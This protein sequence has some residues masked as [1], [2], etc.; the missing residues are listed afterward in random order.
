MTSRTNYRRLIAAFLLL[1]GLFSVQ[2]PAQAEDIDLFTI[3]PEVSTQ[4]PNVLIIL[5][6]SANWDQTDPVEG[7]KRSRW[8]LSAMSSTI[9]ALTDQF[10][11]GLMMFAETGNPNDNI[12]G[13]VMR[14]GMRWMNSTNRSALVNFFNSVDSGFDKS[15][16]TSMGL[17]F[18]EA[19]LY[20]SGRAAYSGIGKAKR[21]YLGNDWST[22]G[23][24]QQTAPIAMQTA[25]NA[26]WNL[27]KPADTPLPRNA[28]TDLADTVYNTPVTDACQKNFII[29]IANGPFNDPV[30][31][32]TTATTK[33]AAEGGNT[34]PPTCNVGSQVCDF[35]AGNV[36]D[37]WARFLAN[38]SA[39]NLTKPLVIT[40]TVEVNPI[41]TGQGP[42]T[43]G[44]LESIATQGKGKYFPVS[45]TG[46]GAQ[47]ADALNKIFAEIAAVNS[48]FASSTLPVSVNVRGAFLNQVYMG[49]FR[50]D[51]NSSPRWPGNVKHYALSADS[52]GNVFLVDKAGVAIENP[53]TGFVSP[54]AVSFWTTASTFWD[55]VYYPDAAAPA[56]NTTNSDSPD[57]EFVEKGGAAQRL[58]TVYATTI[59]D[60]TSPRKLYT[61]IGC[62]ADTDLTSSADHTFT[63][64]NTNI[65]ATLMGITGTLSVNSLS[66]VG[67][68]VTAS[69]TA[70]GFLNGQVVQI[71]GATQAEYN[72]SHNITVVDANTFTYGITETPA[73]PAT[74]NSGTTLTAAK[75]G[76][77]QLVNSLTSSGSTATATVLLGHG[78][79]DGQS[80]TMSGASQAEYDGTYNITFISPTQ[81]SYTITTGPANPT[82]QGNIIVTQGDGGTASSAVSSMTRSGT[83]VTV[84][85]SSSVF[86]GGDT[87]A[88]VQI[89]GASPVVYNVSGRSC[90]RGVGNK[91]LTFELDATELT[92]QSPDPSLVIQADASVTRTIASMTRPVG[93]GT[94]TVVTTA[95]H[96]YSS[97]DAV[98]ISNAT[99][100][101]YNGNK[102]ITVVD[103][104]T[105]T[106]TLT[107]QPTTPAGGAITATGSGGLNKDDVINWARGENVKLDDN[108]AADA[109]NVRGYLHGDVLHSRPAVI[110][111]N[112]STEPAERDLVV[113]Y[114][115]NDGIIH[116]VK[117]GADD[118]DGF[119]KWGFVP[120]EFYPGFS[121]LYSESPIISSNNRRTYFADGP[122]SIDAVY[123]IDNSDPTNPK[124]RL[125][126]SLGSVRAQIYVGMRRG[127]RF[128][129][130]LDVTNPDVPVYKWKLDSATT[131]FT[132]LGQSW[133][134]AKVV[135]LRLA[136]CPQLGGAGICKV[137]VFGAGYDSPANDPE[138]QGTATMGRGI[139]VVDAV[140]GERIWH[141]GPSVASA[142]SGTYRRTAEMTYAIPADLSVINTDLDVQNLADRIY[143]ADTG[144]NIW[145][146]NVSDSNPANWTVYKLASLRTAGAE[147][148]R[149]FLFAPDVVQF[150]TTTDSVLIGS[151]DREHPHE[152]AILNR[153]YMIKDPHSINNFPELSGSPGVQDPASVVTESNLC[154]LTNNNLQGTDQGL[155]DADKACLATS[156]GWMI[157]LLGNEPPPC[158]AD[159]ICS[160]RPGEKTVTG[161]TTLGGTVIF[162][163]N[164]P[165]QSTLASGQ[166]TGSLGTALIYA[167]SFRDATATIDFDG[168][169]VVDQGDRFVERVGGGFPPTAIPFTT[170]IGDKFYEG[171][172][173]GTKVV[174][175]PT[176]PIGQ[177][178]RVFWNLSVDN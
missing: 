174:Q 5:D 37:E 152:T 59:N 145:R 48:V 75:G 155:I 116:A 74:A 108:T 20:Y 166:C 26:I 160:Q 67:E 150:D 3:N 53:N 96:T 124:E 117:G 79:A 148:A 153:Y 85:T 65:T 68:T 91:R 161:A 89:T 146:V 71:Q 76:A 134:E 143:A 99:D 100:A 114:G 84:D 49:V 154:D 101:L 42:N 31:S 55:P 176:S 149:K 141:T 92:P 16:N 130:S 102:T 12:D 158:G 113:Y 58:R 25:S 38:P 47:I 39:T 22:V 78:Y 138:T 172:I 173:T 171:A 86:G 133:S 64:G 169:G 128:Y 151:G 111:Y 83:T 62:P 41:T 63:T 11:V 105:F 127:G 131:G 6:S 15:N 36:S 109:A 40:Y 50:P 21:D 144:G 118:S 97:G 163:T 140:T 98:T 139:F 136:N 30:N 1:A 87:C 94:V 66:R 8:V 147:N 120:T 13:G 167:I 43:S 157:R 90:L 57:G 4:R 132:E 170:K 115:G 61:C 70:H 17:A 77:P 135:K 51:A 165:V 32:N 177:R 122:I 119:E 10:N 24:A 103:A 54:S 52:S 175:P 129:Y 110:N 178:Y 81:F 72:G 142:G 44:L 123:A 60:A 112:R 45:S 106:F 164:T 88:S 73:S 125:E 104:T 168:N 2:F 33:L 28:L 69:V 156:K 80:V 159:G 95:A 137:L 46:G 121:R 162:A 7:D 82:T 23:A 14:M 18:N 56:P 29:Y 93:S 107:P 19:Y 9:S 126:P 27:V 34:E 35:L